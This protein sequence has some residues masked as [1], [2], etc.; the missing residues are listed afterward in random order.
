MTEKNTIP[1]SPASQMPPPDEVAP[2]ARRLMRLADKVALATI[3]PQQGSPF[4]SLTGVATMMDATPVLLMSDIS[5]HSIN[6]AADPRASLLFDGT[7]DHAN[8]LTE[9]RVTVNGRIVRID[10][11]HAEQRFMARHPKAFYAQF[12]DFSFY[13]MQIEDAHFVGGFGTALSVPANILLLREET[14]AG[15][16]AAEADIL[17]HM[18]E[19]H[20]EAVRNMA[21][22]LCRTGEGPWQMT[23]LDPEG[24]D[25]MARKKRCRL[26]FPTPVSDAGE[27][28]EMLVSL[29]RQARNP[30]NAGTPE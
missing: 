14:Y 4:L 13:E 19:Q 27:V 29:A 6:L 21:V 20:G 5:R 24:C 16:L 1:P 3:D 2:A 9:D 25:F 28:R 23:G 12:A 30:E 7:G 11:P 26:P 22:N 8:P 18:N 15:L 17:D 10:H